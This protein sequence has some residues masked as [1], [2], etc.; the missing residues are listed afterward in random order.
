[1]VDRFVA[2]KS[3]SAALLDA[4]YAACHPT[5]APAFFLARGKSAWDARLSRAFDSVLGVGTLTRKLR[6]F[7]T[8][9]VGAN[10][11]T[12]LE[13]SLVSADSPGG[14]ATLS[15]S[16]IGG[17]P[18]EKASLSSSI[19]VTWTSGTGDRVLFG[20][21]AAFQATSLAAELGQAVA[22]AEVPS[23]TGLASA[24]AHS[25]SCHDV[26]S[27]L[28][29][30]TGTEFAYGTCGESCVVSLCETALASMW[31]RAVEPSGAPSK[32]DLSANG[33]V[34]ALSDAAAPLSFDGSWVGTATVGGRQA[35][36][37]GAASGTTDRASVP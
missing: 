11:S 2:K 16:T 14:K 12:A 25:L 32:L 35:R 26:A 36:V 5:A 15:F 37:S 30:S 10:G 29:G 31:V 23:A 21:S 22:V 3:D 18:A 9:G 24:L 6:S 27:V 28:V 17:I 7:L 33:A 34:T 13:G 8:A 19:D 1:M 4:M 20:G